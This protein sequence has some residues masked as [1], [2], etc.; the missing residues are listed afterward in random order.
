MTK[1][2]GVTSLL[3]YLNSVNYPLTEEQLRMFL[4][5]RKIP[6]SSFGDT[7]FFDLGHIDW[8]IAEQRKIESAT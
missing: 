3:E 6:H 7:L 5:Q 1:I 4:D 2:Q 8:W